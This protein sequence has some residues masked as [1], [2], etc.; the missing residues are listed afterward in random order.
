MWLL[1]DADDTL[2]ENSIYFDRAFDQFVEL[3]DHSH[4][5][6]AEIREVLDEIE[7]GREV[8]PQRLLSG[9]PHRQ[10]EKR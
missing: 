4:L 6:A 2:W 5:S 3:L 7:L 1:I 10:R 8:R 9:V